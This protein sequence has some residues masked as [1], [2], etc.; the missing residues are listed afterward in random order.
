MTTIT[1]S[2]LMRAK[3][4][5]GL[6]DTS[7]LAVLECLLHQPRC[8]SEVVAMTGLSQPNV[9]NHLACLYDCGLV[10]R[11]QQGRFVYYRLADPRVASILDEI[12][13]VVSSIEQKLEDCNN[14]EETELV[15]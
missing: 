9:S 4:L 6:A 5:R 2:M 11:V 3:L 12:E 13:K 1:S 8:V 15:R 14:Y 10:G 7:R